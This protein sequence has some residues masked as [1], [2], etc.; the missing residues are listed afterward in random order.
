MAVSRH[1]NSVRPLLVE[2]QQL[3][4]SFTMLRQMEQRPG[5]CQRMVAEA[6]ETTATLMGDTELAGR[7]WGLRD[8]LSE[9]LE[10]EE[11]GTGRTTALLRQALKSEKPVIFYVV[12]SQ[13]LVE[14]CARIVTDVLK[15]DIR[16]YNATQGEFALCDGRELRLVPL[17]RWKMPGY[18]MGLTDVDVV[19]DHYMP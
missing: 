15:P 8:Y 18:R 3:T 13:N 2:R 4:A 19:F 14:Y 11:C 12:A 1:P 6:L 17:A 7:I 5:D 9:L 16:R 10:R